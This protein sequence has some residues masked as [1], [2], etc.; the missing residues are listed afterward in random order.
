MGSVTN[1]I[2]TIVLPA[3]LA[4]QTVSTVLFS[5][6]SSRRQSVMHKL[7]D[8]DVGIVRYSKLPFQ[9]KAID[10]IR[11]CGDH[12]LLTANTPTIQYSQPNVNNVLPTLIYENTFFSIDIANAF[13]YK[14]W[15]N[16][17]ASR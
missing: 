16:L 13:Q 10:G 1:P 9:T 7:T 15:A 8:P 17:P 6:L 14:S 11:S 12:W 4:Y 3:P 2:S 5:S